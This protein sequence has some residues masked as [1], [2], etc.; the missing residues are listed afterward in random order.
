MPSVR[1]AAQRSIH[2]VANSE[3]LSS[4][5]RKLGEKAEMRPAVLVPTMRLA[6]ISTRPTR[7]LLSA[8]SSPT[9]W[10]STAGFTGLPLDWHSRT[11][12]WPSFRAF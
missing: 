8:A 9:T 4:R 7:V 2:F 5:G 11:S 10:W 3:L 6:G 12:F 1:W